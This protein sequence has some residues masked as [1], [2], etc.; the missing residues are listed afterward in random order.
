MSDIPPCGRLEGLGDDLTEAARILADVEEDAK[1][2]FEARHTGR[3]HRSLRLQLVNR[4]HGCT[5]L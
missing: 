5:L 4:H 1:E 3:G 2:R